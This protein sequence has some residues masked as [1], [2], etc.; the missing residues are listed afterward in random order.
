MGKEIN[1][2]KSEIG[3]FL[4]RDCSGWINLLVSV[5]FFVDIC[6]YKVEGIC[7]FGYELVYHSLQDSKRSFTAR[8]LLILL[9][10]YLSTITRLGDS[11]SLTSP[12]ILNSQIPSK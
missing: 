6:G 4:E 8:Q 1:P 5:I 2:N 3:I 10:T 9:Q 7:L 11:I 12:Q